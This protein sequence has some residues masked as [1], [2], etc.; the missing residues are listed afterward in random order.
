MLRLRVGISIDP[1]W[2]S[3]SDAS[4]D[5]EERAILDAAATASEHRRTTKGSKQQTSKPKNKKTDNGDDDGLRTSN[6]LYLGHLPKHCEEQELRAF[7][8]QFG[9]VK[10]VRVSRSSKPP[11]RSRGYAFCQMTSSQVASIVADTLSGYL[12]F[13]QKRLV[14]QL[15]PQNKLDKKLF[16]P[17]PKDK[18]VNALK[19]KKQRKLVKQRTSKVKS[20]DKIQAVTNRLLTRER[21]KR[22]RLQ[23]LGI[24][25]DFPGY[26][27]GVGVTTDDDDNN[28]GEKEKST[29]KTKKNKT[30]TEQ[31]ESSSTKTPS[32]K[33][34]SG[35]KTK[36]AGGTSS[37]RKKRRS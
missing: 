35:K 5:E 22:Q 1:E 11:F 2:D 16:F 26:Q 9:Q 20:L 24:D 31:K 14:C 25:Y 29:P 15:L 21:R 10:N 27:Q 33:S 18:S 19:W 12:L 23:E 7:L 8:S 36:S 17:T 34:S 13:G 6:V 30:V 4:E 28:K 3:H 32:K 37:S